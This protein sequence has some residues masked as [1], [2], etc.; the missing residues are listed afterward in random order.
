MVWFL[1]M[2]Y[3]VIIP[4]SGQQQEARRYSTKSN[5]SSSSSLD[6]GLSSEKSLLK[7]FGRCIAMDSVSLVLDALQIDCT[8]HEVLLLLLL[9]IQHPLI[10][11]NH[12][13]YHPHFHLVCWEVIIWFSDF[14]LPDW[15][16]AGLFCALYAGPL[17]FRK[18]QIFSP[19]TRLFSS[20]TRIPGLKIKVFK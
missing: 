9:L 2:F 4:G 5:C 8:Q 1:S 16:N 15:H 7:A 17:F 14:F 10:I 11:A 20:K 13:I 19:K 18:T 3:V 12:R 6:D